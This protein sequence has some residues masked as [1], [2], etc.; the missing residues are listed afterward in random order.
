[1]TRYTKNGKR[2]GRPL[3]YDYMP[4]DG[5]RMVIDPAALRY[6]RAVRGFTREELAERA[7][8]SLEALRSYEKGRR[9]PGEKPFRRMFIALGIGPEDLLFPGGRYVKSI[10]EDEDDEDQRR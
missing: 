3:K 2:V 8:V 10:E 9:C 1:M 4:R 5:G 7:H 6:W